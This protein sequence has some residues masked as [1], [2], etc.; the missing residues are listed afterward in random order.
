M[1]AAD[2]LLIPER[3]SNPG[4]LLISK[5]LHPQTHVLYM[6]CGNNNK[7]KTL[8]CPVFCS[9]VHASITCPLTHKHAHPPLALS[10]L[11]HLQCITV[12]PFCSI[13]GSVSSLLLAC[14]AAFPDGPS[15]RPLICTTGS[16]LT[17]S[18]C[19]SRDPCAIRETNKSPGG[20]EK[21]SKV[22]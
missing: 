17:A 10:F 3:H 14:S 8:I 13:H 4:Q 16:P 20:Q 21:M 11:L 6:A 7:G 12:G 19:R 15:C 2:I 22:H 9:Y 18:Y 5:S 1:C